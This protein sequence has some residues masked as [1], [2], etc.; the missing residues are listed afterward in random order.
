MGI[1][2]TWLPVGSL[3]MYLLAPTLATKLGWQSVWWFG[4]G[5]AGLVFILFAVFMRTPTTPPEVRVS[6]G[7]KMGLLPAL[8]NPSI[9]LLGLAFAVYNLGLAGHN[10]YYPTFL[11]SVRGFDIKLVA[12]T[13]SL[14]PA[15]VMFGLNLGM[16][17][18]PLVFGALV[19]RGGWVTAG[20]AMIPVL[21]AGFIPC[22]QERG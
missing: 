21:L 10:T 2:A 8:A 18:G 4:A 22:K 20:Y 11:S 12:S 16:F 5:F 13:A 6:K 9:W 19:E 3:V 14:G 7:V 1:W 17:A 15:V